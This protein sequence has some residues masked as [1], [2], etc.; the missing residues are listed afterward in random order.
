[1]AAPLTSTIG[2]AQLNLESLGSSE[3]LREDFREIE[4][5]AQS[6]R[7]YLGRLSRLSRYLPEEASCPA[8]EFLSDLQALTSSLALSGGN[9]LV[10]EGNEKPP[11]EELAVNPWLARVTCLA[12]LG[13][14]CRLPSAT[15]NVTRG[16]N[17]LLLKFPALDDRREYGAPHAWGC[18][19]L[20][21]RL[22]EAQSSLHLE[23]GQDSWTLSLSLSSHGLS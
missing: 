8:G 9:E 18:C 7:M 13:S 21:R 3:E 10:W 5:S 15:V 11:S 23:V 4:Q 16:P 6:L 2:Y 1:M 14:V 22:I 17:A 20:G 19:D 12:I